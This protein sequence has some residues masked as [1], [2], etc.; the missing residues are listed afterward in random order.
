V[1]I[2][3]E[4]MRPIEPMRVATNHDR[5]GEHHQVDGQRPAQPGEAESRHGR[6]ELE[7]VNSLRMPTTRTT[8]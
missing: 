6:T 1:V 2:G 4:A 8:S 5:R 3:I 7:F